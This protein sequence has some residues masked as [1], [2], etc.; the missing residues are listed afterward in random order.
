M[1]HNAAYSTGGGVR[2]TFFNFEGAKIND[3]LGP[4]GVRPPGY[5]PA[6]EGV[7]VISSHNPGDTFP[8]GITTVTYTA[9]DP[10]GNLATTSFNV[11]V[12]GIIWTRC[13]IALKQFV[14][15]HFHQRPA[16]GLY[17][18]YGVA[19]LCVFFFLYATSLTQRRTLFSET[20]VC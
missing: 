5:A 12:T 10:Y 13:W 9:T 8:I 15:L 4:P 18:N 3:S 1:F 20:R 17:E 16:I 11:V 14:F 6:N 19:R 2:A 7:T